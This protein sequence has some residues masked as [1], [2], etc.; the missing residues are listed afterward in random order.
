MWPNRLII[1]LNVMWSTLP[2]AMLMILAG[3]QGVPEET[4]EAAQI[5]GAGT[6]SV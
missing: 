2:F 4:L 5:D 1:L 3:L 6:L